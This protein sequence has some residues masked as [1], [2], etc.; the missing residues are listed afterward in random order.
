MVPRDA[1]QQSIASV[2]GQPLSE[3]V[4][5]VT[6]AGSGLG[7]AYALDLARHGA[8]VVVNDL[9]LGLDGGSGDQSAAGRV[10]AEIEAAGGHAVA[11]HHD[12][13]DWEQ[14]GALVE[15][16]VTTFGDLH[17]LV[18]SAGFLRDR[19]LARMSEDEWDTV[20][21]V[22]LKGQAAPAHHA[23]AWWR[24][25]AE[26]DGPSDRSIVLI[27][28]AS[29]LRPSFG[30][31]NYGAAK[32]GVLGLAQVAALEGARHGVRANVVAPSARTRMTAS[33]PLVAES[34]AVDPVRFEPAAVAS[35]V[36]WLASPTCRASRQV[37]YTDGRRVALLGLAPV[38]ADFD[39]AAGWTIE[40]LEEAVGEALVLQPG[41]DELLR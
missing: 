14:A 16:A 33:D 17:V 6:G 2:T 39:R 5:I 18:A 28:S 12:V 32:A 24:D 31:A 36:T 29:G 20:V 38:L 40:A 9:G 26:A 27:S 30:Q 15:L 34:A 3:R 13:A 22:H 21:R 8:S 19:T 10:V 35:I 7:R 11:S 4:A 37:V 1:C 25:R 23:L 41:L